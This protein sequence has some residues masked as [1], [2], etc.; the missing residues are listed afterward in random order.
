M[1]ITFAYITSVAVIPI[2][3]C[4]VISF[5]LPLVAVVRAYPKSI[6]WT[7]T[8]GLG[9]WVR[10]SRYCVVAGDVDRVLLGTAAIVASG[11]KTRKGPT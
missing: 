7:V 8:L 11:S 5:F 3:V 1:A 4:L 6:A 2:P 10:L 9:E